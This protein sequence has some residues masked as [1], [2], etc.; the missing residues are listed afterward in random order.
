MKAAYYPSPGQVA[1]H[2]VPEPELRHRDEVKL[3]IRYV[4][5]C[6]DDISLYK[7]G[8]RS[9]PLPKSIV[10]H[11]FSGEIEDLGELAYHAGFRI[12]DAVSGYAWN[13]C[14]ACRYCKSGLEAHCSNA[15]CIS[16]LAEHVVLNMR[17]IQKLRPGVPLEHGIFTDAIGYCLYNGLK[18]RGIAVDA[19]VMIFGCN[20]FSLILLQLIKLFSGAT[21]SIADKDERKLELARTLGADHAFSSEVTTVLRNTA[22]I[23]K[24]H[25]YDHIFEM[26]RDPKM[27]GL[28]GTI[29]S[30]RGDIRYSYL[31]GYTTSNDV[32]LMEL[33]RKE[34]T[35]SPFFL[36]PYSLPRAVS[37]IPRLALQPLITDIYPPSEVSRAYHAQESGASIRL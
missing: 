22:G 31:Y 5:V 3:R 16:V 11:E 18:D 37:V 29:A 12:G 21:V 1:L 14:G 27:L 24:D 36:V 30:V 34:V 19:H 13:F 6:D 25:G 32:N 4:G 26:S 9:W 35:L 15:A 10:G 23:T 7:G 28:T 17:Q 20:T 8:N 33:Y 2:D